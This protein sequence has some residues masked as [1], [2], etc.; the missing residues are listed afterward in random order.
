MPEFNRLV[1]AKGRYNVIMAE[2]FKELEKQL[3]ATYMF[4]LFQTEKQ[5]T[6]ATW[7]YDEVDSSV[8][9]VVFI[10]RRRFFCLFF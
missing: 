4:Y 7:S 3:Q 5:L 8:Y 1:A 9:D 2:K 10:S 6:F